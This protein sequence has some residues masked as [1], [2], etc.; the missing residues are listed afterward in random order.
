MEEKCL[1]PELVSEYFPPSVYFAFISAAWR[2][3]GVGGAGSEFVVP[4][5]NQHRVQTSERASRSG[6]AG[7]DALF[8]HG[9]M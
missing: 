5:S 1:T 3:G 9:R 2:M 6:C 4:N 7:R 8:W